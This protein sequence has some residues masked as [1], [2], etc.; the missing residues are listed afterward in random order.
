M[1]EIGDRM[2]N[3]P[4][5][6]AGHH[7]IGGKRPGLGGALSCFRQFRDLG[8]GSRSYRPRHTPMERKTLFDIWRPALMKAAGIK[9]ETLNTGLDP[10][11]AA[12]ILSAHLAG[13]PDVNYIYGSDWRFGS[14]RPERL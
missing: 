2:D 6:T 11:S 9:A 10:A 4:Y 14:D 12:N 8:K 3:N 13:N 7:A 1:P 5:R